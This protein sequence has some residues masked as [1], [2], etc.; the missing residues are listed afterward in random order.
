[1]LRWRKVEISGGFLLLAAGLYYLDSQGVVLWAALAAALHE[2]G[3][4]L[5]IRL[6]GGRVTVLR[7]TCVGAEMVLSARR[8][9]SVPGQLCAALA[10]PAVNLALAFSVARL[11]EGER[12]FLFA[13]LNLALGLFNLLP[14]AQ[15][16]GGRALRCVLLLLGWEERASRVVRAVSAGLALL[17]AAAGAFA[18]GRGGNVTLL[19][20]ALWLLGAAVVPEEGEKRKKRRRRRKICLHSR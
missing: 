6:F 13:G 8:P 12:G 9:L 17:L 3:H 5:V 11:A 10:G 7:L 15:L 14:A 18:L 19:L 20:T 4:Y 16:D 2:L 1:M